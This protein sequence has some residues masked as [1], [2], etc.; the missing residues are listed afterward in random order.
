MASNV[1]APK[2]RARS[3]DQGE[4]DLCSLYA[5]AN[6][7]VETLMKE[8]VDIGLDEVVAKLQQLDFVK[9]K[10]GHHVTEFDGAKLKILKERGTGGTIENVTL[11][12]KKHNIDRELLQHVKDENISCV[13][14]YIR[15]DCNGE[16]H[17]VFIDTVETQDHI[18]WISILPTLLIPWIPWISKRS[19]TENFICINS[20]GSYDKNPVI[21]VFQEGNRVFEVKGTVQRLETEYQSADKNIAMS[22]CKGLNWPLWT[23]LAFISITAYNPFDAVCMYIQMIICSF[24]TVLLMTISECSVFTSNRL[25]PNIKNKTIWKIIK[26]YV[27]YSIRALLGFSIVLMQVLVVMY[28]FFIILALGNYYE[29]RKF[30]AEPLFFVLMYKLRVEFEK[31]HQQ[32]T[33][34]EL[35]FDKYL[36]YLIPS[37]GCLRLLYLNLN[38]NLNM[39]V[40]VAVCISAIL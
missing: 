7:T 4:T 1:A 34:N 22:I 38:L 12:I 27:C 8:N 13:L 24:L 21:D 23:S 19:G 40:I 10:G 16:R 2:A 9:V 37:V 28:L 26:A 36:K 3:Q 17:C 35:A 5:I 11:E 25:K 32:L 15:Q 20:W 33:S 29:D 6:A 39:Y 14:D 31:I 30:I 18:N